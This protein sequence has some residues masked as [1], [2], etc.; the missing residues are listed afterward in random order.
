VVTLQKTGKTILIGCVVIFLVLCIIVVA[1]GAAIGIPAYQEQQRVKAERAAYGSAAREWNS[2]VPII[3]VETK[4]F[5]GIWKEISALRDDIATAWLSGNKSD[6]SKAGS[7]MGSKITDL[8]KTMKELRS[9]NDDRRKIVG[10]MRAAMR[11]HKG[12]YYREPDIENADKTVKDTDKLYAQ[13][14]KLLDVVKQEQDWYDKDLA[15]KADLAAMS[16]A[17]SDLWGKYD[18][19]A[20]DLDKLDKTGATQGE[21]PV[22]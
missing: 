12:T 17:L 20:L 8:E 19:L 3:D 2:T 16:N 11:I 5:S 21:M 6:E 18:K 14:G 4:Q 10:S 1:G 7:D 13:Y 9:T 22:S 15:G